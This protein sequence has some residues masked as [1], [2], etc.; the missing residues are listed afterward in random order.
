MSDPGT[1]PMLPSPHPHLDLRTR[2]ALWIIG[3]FAPR[4]QRVPRQRK[5]ARHSPEAVR[6]RLAADGAYLRAELAEFFRSQPGR[7]VWLTEIAARPAEARQAINVL[8][9]QGEP[10]GE[11]L[12]GEAWIYLPVPAPV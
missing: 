3:L 4:P 7:L 5:V 2:F 10:I 12:T 1:G 8:R 9:D 11:A 6:Q